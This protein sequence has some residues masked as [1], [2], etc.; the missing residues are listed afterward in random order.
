MLSA[1]FCSKSLFLLSSDTGML[2][3]HVS[4]DN[5]IPFP[6]GFQNEKYTIFITVTNSLG[7]ILPLLQP[8]MHTRMQFLY[9]H[10]VYI[11]MFQE[12]LENAYKPSSLTSKSSPKSSQLMA[13]HSVQFYHHLRHQQCILS[14]NIDIAHDPGTVGFQGSFAYRLL[15]YRS[16]EGQG[17]HFYEHCIA[18]ISSQTDELLMQLQ[19]LLLPGQL[20]LIS[21]VSKKLCL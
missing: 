20:Y 11:L 8:D 16:L 13:N 3:S 19:H 5:Q 2:L 4:Q 1:S 17:F 21:S 7:S 9:L 10:K 14:G 12:K 18:F 15:W 6:Q